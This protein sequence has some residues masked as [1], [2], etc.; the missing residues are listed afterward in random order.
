MLLS[1]ALPSHSVVWMDKTCYILE[2][3]FGD[4]DAVALDNGEDY[5]KLSE[6][7]AAIDSIDLS[8]S[9]PQ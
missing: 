6:F 5:G 2:T 7:V 1:L 8:A 3:L 9:L 4:P